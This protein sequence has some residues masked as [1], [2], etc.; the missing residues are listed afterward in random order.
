MGFLDQPLEFLIFGNPRQ[1]ATI[2]GYIT[3][4]ESTTDSLEIT[5]QPVQQGAMIADHAFNKPTTF[6]AQLQFVPTLFTSLKSIYQNLIDLQATREPF[7]IATP[8]RI[9]KDM[10]FQTLSQT[11]DKRTENVLS[12]NATF[13]QIIIV[14]ISVVQVP[15][16]RQQNA[17]RTGATENAGK[18]SAALT[19]FQGVSQTT[20]G[21]SRL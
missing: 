14:N 9:Y 8:K 18:K 15:R 4:G 17:G 1:I 2:S 3:V 10:L 11:T 7:T 5:Q 12:V 6:S 13:Q 21:F 16:I 20:Q 19:L